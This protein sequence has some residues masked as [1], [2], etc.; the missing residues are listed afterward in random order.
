LPRPKGSKNKSNLPVNIKCLKCR[1][2]KLS[3]NSFYMNG[4]QL[5]SSEKLEICKICINEF[6]GDKDSSGYL[7]R[8]NQVLAIM[9]KPFLIDLWNQRDRDWSRYIPQLSSFK[10]YHGM[11]YANSTQ[12]KNNNINGIVLESSI[13][14]SDIN[15][16]Q[17]VELTKEQLRHLVDFW[18]KGFELEE[19]EFLQMEYEELV[20]GYECDTRAMELLFQEVAQTRLTIKTKRSKSESVDKEVKTMQDLLGSAN[21][22]PMQET[23][24]NATEQ[25]TF[26]TLIKK[27]ENERPLPEPD[28]IWSDVDYIKKYISTWFFGHLT[29]MM[30]MKSESFDE[31]EE[32]IAKYTVENSESEDEDDS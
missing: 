16:I 7:D 1:K 11:T 5:F 21:I 20:N 18:G 25:A 31:Y 14:D 29:K 19:Y 3:S 32:E 4:N 6:I 12:F 2:E 15:D 17:K 26:G 9:D 28:P 24:A 10:Q 13:T 27:Y 30:G 8:V 23:G 22:K